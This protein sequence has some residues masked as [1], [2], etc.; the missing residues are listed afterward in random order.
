MISPRS[1][2]ARSDFRPKLEGSFLA[3]FCV[4]NKILEEFA[5]RLLVLPWVY[6]MITVGSQKMTFLFVFFRPQV[7]NTGMTL[8]K[9]AAVMRVGTQPRFERKAG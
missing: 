2:L 5:S 3:S 7:V 9:R 8:S 1:T 6:K 4:Q